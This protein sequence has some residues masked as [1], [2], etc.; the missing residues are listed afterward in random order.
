MTE[1][2]DLVNMEGEL[3]PEILPADIRLSIQGSV[4][5]FLSA[6]NGAVDIIPAK[7][8]IP[9]TSAVEI[10]ADDSFGSSVTVTSTDAFRTFEKSVNSLEVRA[11]GKAL[12]PG[13]RLRAIMRLAPEE[14]FRLDVTNEGASIRSGRVV[15]QVPVI[16]GKGLPG[17]PDTANIALREFNV[18]DFVSALSLTL[19]AT[20][21]FT[22]RMSLTQLSLVKGVLTGCDG[23]RVH[24]IL[25]SKKS[26]L[27]TTLPYNFA[28]TLLSELRSTSAEKFYLGASDK[29]VVAQIGKVTL[30]GQRLTLPY[31]NVDHLLLE[32]A[33]L[34]TDSLTLP[35]RVLSEAVKHVRISADP[36]LAAVSLT[37]RKLKGTW[38]VLV[39]A[40][41]KTGNASQEVIS[42]IE[43]TGDSPREEHLNFKYLLEFLEC[44]S[45][46]TVV[47][48]L[49]ASTKTKISPLYVK[50]GRFEGVIQPMVVYT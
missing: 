29:T 21:K 1:L 2:L 26:E 10:T 14:T 48:N 43:F 39:Q 36:D 11:A 34:N 4:Q 42:D 47:F 3:A 13:K 32:P 27:E 45:S 9:N 16:S 38:V 12:L 31:P 40:V 7:E 37:V 20:A 18:A 8:V 25:V 35:T 33:M 49:G 17:G 23:T 44:V 30:T 50:N 22:A 6:L 15:W 28:E 24:R 19:S 46:E 41:D 5:E